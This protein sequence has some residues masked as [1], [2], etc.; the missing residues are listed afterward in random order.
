MILLFLVCRRPGTVAR[1]TER[2]G[3]AGCFLGCTCLVGGGARR[4]MDGTAPGVLLRVRRWCVRGA[5]CRVRLAVGFVDV[6]TFSLTLCGCSSTGAVV[7]M[8]G[9]VGCCCLPLMRLDSAV[10]ALLSFVVNFAVGTTSPNSLVNSSTCSSGVN[11]GTCACCG[12]NSA[13][14]DTR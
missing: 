11:D 1:R 9:S 3:L 6:V 13:D 14:P 8:L 12:K 4:W 7:D 5:R 10:S 2:L